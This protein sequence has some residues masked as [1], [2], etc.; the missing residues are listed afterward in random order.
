MPLFALVITLWFAPAPSG[1]GQFFPPWL[2]LTL[3]VPL[4]VGIDFGPAPLCTEPPFSLEYE[5]GPFLNPVF[6]VCQLP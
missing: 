3:E 6:S 4:P 5:T 2:S 1:L